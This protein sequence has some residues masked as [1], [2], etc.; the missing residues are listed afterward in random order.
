MYPTWP[1]Y[2]QHKS[3]GQQSGIYDS[4]I[5]INWERL[6]VDRISC[7]RRSQIFGASYLKDL[8]P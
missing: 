5:L 7:G 4:I 8:K 2:L 1:I 6:F 3:Q